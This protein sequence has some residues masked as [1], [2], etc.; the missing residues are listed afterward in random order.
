PR[1]LLLVTALHPHQRPVP[2]HLDAVQGELELAFAVSAP[3]VSQG[4]PNALVPNDDLAR[5]V[6]AGRNL[7]FELVVGDWVVLD[8]HGHAL[9][10]G[11]V[12]GTLGHGPALH[13]A[14]QL[15]AQV[16]VQAA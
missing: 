8:L 15:Q 11:I 2:A 12:A 4:G 3:G 10:L 16:V 14:A 13:H 6:L 1:R 7:A 9:V 5:A